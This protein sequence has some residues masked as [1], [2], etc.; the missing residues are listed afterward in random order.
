MTPADIPEEGAGQGIKKTIK[1]L[2]SMKGGSPSLIVAV[3]W[4]IQWT[5]A[6]TT[7]GRRLTMVLFNVIL[8]IF[9]EGFPFDS[10]EPA[11]SFTSEVII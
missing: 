11:A 1:Q 4:C 10:G 8:S 9:R 6:C 5:L 3:R 7:M 2:R